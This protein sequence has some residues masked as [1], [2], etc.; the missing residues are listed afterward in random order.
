VELNYRVVLRTRSTDS[1]YFWVGEDPEEWWATGWGD[2]LLRRQPCY[3]CDVS[4]GD[5]RLLL[6]GVVSGRRDGSSAQTLIRYELAI[7]RSSDDGGLPQ[8]QVDWIIRAWWQQRNLTSNAP[9]Q[10]GLDLDDVL[11]REA[12]ARDVSVDIL[13][14]GRDAL[15]VESALRR[16]PGVS[17]IQSPDDPG[18]AAWVGSDHP[19]VPEYLHGSTS[20]AYFAAVSPADADAGL[21]LRRDVLVIADGDAK[22]HAR[23]EIQVTRPK[24]RAAEAP[25]PPSK[26]QL[27][28]WAIILFALLVVLTAVAI[29]L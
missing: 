17:A 23:R 11:A 27:R 16:L 6:T 1:D 26:Y 7:G 3:L 22:F 10:L 21:A 24:D 4:A 29:L 18:N 15:A 28:L 2:S 12:A 20:L 25:H 8:T 19:S 9:W 13:L 5:V 14:E